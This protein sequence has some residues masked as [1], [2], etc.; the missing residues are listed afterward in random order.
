MIFGNPI[1]EKVIPEQCAQQ[2]GFTAA[3]N[4]CDDLHLT[5]PHKGDELVQIAF[6]FDFHDASSVENLSVL[7]YY[8][9][10]D[11]IHHFEGKSRSQLKCSRIYPIIFQ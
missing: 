2:I 10:M 1:V 3:A 6:P 11:I 9:S 4:T 5:I 7:S 8:F